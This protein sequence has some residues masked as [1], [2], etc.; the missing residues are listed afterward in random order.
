MSAK[1][2]IDWLI[3]KY[4]GQYNLAQIRTLLKR[5]AEWWQ[6]KPSQELRLHALM[7]EAQY[8]IEAIAAATLLGYG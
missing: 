8:H 7:V 1:E 2:T 6:E 4:P 3:R 5:F